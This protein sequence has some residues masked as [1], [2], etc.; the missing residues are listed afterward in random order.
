MPKTTPHNEIH[1][2]RRQ[3]GLSQDELAFLLGIEA[4]S[5]VSRHETGAREPQLG[6]VLGYELVF[7]R[8]A[9][10]IFS[11]DAHQVDSII[12]RNAT[13]LRS[14]LKGEEPSPLQARKLA[15]LDSLL[16][17]PGHD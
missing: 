9:H 11:G 16:G 2:L 15:F 13:T 14:K 5:R 1:R 3:A 7:R 6:A 10:E 17:A 8:G 4:G 12:R